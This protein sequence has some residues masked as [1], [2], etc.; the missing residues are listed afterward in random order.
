MATTPTFVPP[1]VSINYA[2]CPADSGA[3]YPR[4]TPCASNWWF[5][6]SRIVLKLKDV[7][8]PFPLFADV[9]TE[10]NWD[11]FF[12]APYF[13]HDSPVYPPGAKTI[14]SITDVLPDIFTPGWGGK[15]YGN[16]KCAEGL[17]TF[18]NLD[19]NIMGE[20][21][22]IVNASSNNW[23]CLFVTNESKLLF[24]N[25]DN[26]T[27]TGINWIPLQAAWF[28]QMEA[29]EGQATVDN[30]LY[31]TFEPKVVNYMNTLPLSFK[32]VNRG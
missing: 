23:E 32:L 2:D 11:L 28:G 22:T 8:N 3:V 26:L 24:L 14:T 4:I 7:P 20:L 1:R 30:K 25:Q 19:G 27:P 18:A 10:A 9:D 17:M 12:A 15:I 6:V 21:Q 31:L 29:A 16:S 5:N 13:Q